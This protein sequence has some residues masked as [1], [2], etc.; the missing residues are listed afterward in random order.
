[1]SIQKKVGILTDFPTRQSLKKAL[2]NVA[3]VVLQVKAKHTT[4]R[5]VPQPDKGFA[6]QDHV[7]DSAAA[8]EAEIL[9]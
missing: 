3:V 4:M 9:C 5:V 8:S 6:L 1:M 7:N 2:T